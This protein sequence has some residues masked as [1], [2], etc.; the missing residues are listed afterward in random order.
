ML[1]FGIAADIFTAVYAAE[2]ASNPVTDIVLDNI[3]VYAVGT[4][5]VYGPL[6][7]WAFVAVHAMRNPRQIPFVLKTI[8]LFLLIRGIFVSL[9]H[10]APSP[11]R[12]I[13]SAS[14]AV[15]VA[16]LASGG[17]LFF[18]GHTGLPF[19]LALIWWQD[20]RL[21]LIF[22][23]TALFFGTI[24]LLGHVHYSIDVLAAFFI[25]PTI[26]RLAGRL[27]PRDRALMEP[28]PDTA[29]V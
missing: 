3:G 4:I 12:I 27:F 28:E 6:A 24:V 1:A 21:R 2:A 13:V 10:I 22:I 23:A 18:S 17:D 5:F 15:S 26:Y 7:M 25:T 19:L 20:L 14:H 16:G 11:D 29:R 9:T 8:G